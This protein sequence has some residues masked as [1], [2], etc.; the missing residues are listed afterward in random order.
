MHMRRAIASDFPDLATFSAS[1]FIN[2]ALYRYTAPF[3]AEYFDD[4]R[5]YFLRRLKQRNAQPGFISW[6]AVEEKSDALGAD[7]IENVD[8]L[9]EIVGYAF[10]CRY[11]TSEVAK[12]WQGQSWREWLEDTLIDIERRYI[13]VLRLDRST[14]AS[15]VRNLESRKFSSDP[16][17]P[18]PERW[19]LHNLCVDPDFQRRGIGALLMTWGL[20]QA[21][22]EQVPVTLWSSTV[23]EPLYR[24]MGF[25]TWVRR[26]YP[27]FR[28]GAP[29]LVYWP[30]GVKVVKA[31]ED[32]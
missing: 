15:A 11:G 1:A 2:D 31:S 32:Q 19:H 10:W 20:E 7:E 17:S 4:F 8:N 22:E 14:D 21:A 25:Q 23:A 9:E 29:S 6:V 16:F 28:M 26:D 24:K 5:N 12:G 30:H 27:G 3:A 18:L 13:S